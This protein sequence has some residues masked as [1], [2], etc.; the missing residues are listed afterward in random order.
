MKFYKIFSS[1]V[2]GTKFCKWRMKIQVLIT[3]GEG[4][5]LSARGILG[6]EFDKI[7]GYESHLDSLWQCISLRNSIFKDKLL[8][9]F[10]HSRNWKLLVYHSENQEYLKW[11]SP[12][13]E[14]HHIFQLS[15]WLPPSFRF[16]IIC[17]LLCEA[18]HPQSPR[19]K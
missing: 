4:A 10:K 15:P 11:N 16:L 7:W 14:T 18:H 8:G 2:I 6:L 1:T 5:L 19:I 3:F 13:H 17:H 12:A 9:R